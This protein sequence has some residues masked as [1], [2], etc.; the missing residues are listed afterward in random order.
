[1]PT[2]FVTPSSSRRY[3]RAPAINGKVGIEKIS[4]AGRTNRPL[5]HCR[6]HLNHHALAKLHQSRLE[7][8]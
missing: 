2:G 6:F 3:R 1:M 4:I 5:V 7:S 8:N